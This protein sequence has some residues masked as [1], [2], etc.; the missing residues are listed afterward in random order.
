MHLGAG[1][2][3]KD[4]VIDMS[5][6]IVLNKK[7]GDFVKNG[8]LLLTCYT[9]KENVEEIYKDLENSYI[10]VQNKVPN[11]KIIHEIIG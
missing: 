8:E 7:V 5:S 6:G 9:N 1:R 2:A 10:I 4:D 3:T 11:H